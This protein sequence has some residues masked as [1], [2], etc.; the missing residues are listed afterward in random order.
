MIYGGSWELTSHR[1]VKS[2]R[3]EVLL[4]IPGVPKAA[5][6]QRWRSTT[7]S[8]GASDCPKNMAGADVLPLITALVIANMRLHHVLIDGGV[9]LNIISHAAFKQ[10]QIPGSRLRPSCPFSRVGP[11]PMYPLGSIALL[12]TFGTEEN[13]RTE[14][15]VFK[16]A[17][18]NLPFNAIIDRPVLYRFMA[19]SHYGYLVLKMPSPV[20]VLTVQGDRAAAL[21][22]VEKLHALAAEAARPDD[23]GR[24]PL[25]SGTKVPTKVPKVR[26][27]GADDVP[28]KAVQLSTGSSQTTRI[29]GDLEENQEP[30]LVAFLQANVDV[31]AWEPSQMPGIPREVIKHHLKINP[32]ARP[33]SQK[34]CRQ[35]VERQ[36]FIQKE[37][38]KLLDTGFIEEVHHPVW[39]NNP[40]IVPKANGKLRMCID[41]TSLNNACPKDPY[42][43]PR[44]DQ[45][46]DSTSG[47]D[48]LS[49]LDA[50]SGFHQIQM[51][52]EDRK[53][54]AFV[55]VDGLYC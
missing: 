35:S 17:E 18:V 32:D 6:H 14:N 34:P 16:V 28:V 53:H 12:V 20:G 29:A 27:S 15:V 1:N 55:T 10:L 54:T 9:G 42:P 24:N 5:P 40:V 31:F 21:A 25:T 45:I 19:I 2:L 47:S 23:G 41:Y 50:Y 3:R 51:F 13:F 33:V 38:R 7:V 52:R 30:A 11:Q 46:V 22:A 26:P 44:I 8:F 4:A 43:L 48:L 37:V 49:F 39:M 36:D